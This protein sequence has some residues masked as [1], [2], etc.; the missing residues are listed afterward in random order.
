MSW[1]A[2]PENIHH[3]QVEVYCTDGCNYQCL[4]FVFFSLED[5]VPETQSRCRQLW[6]KIGDEF[7]EKLIKNDEQLK[8]KMNFVVEAGQPKHYP[9]FGKY[10]QMRSFSISGLL[11][12]SKT[13]L[14]RNLFIPRPIYISPFSILDSRQFFL[15]FSIQCRQH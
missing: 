4:Q 6:E 10:F 14:P 13:C 12:K 7:I 5:S 15:I 2:R 11:Y 8:E 9:I 1:A 3:R